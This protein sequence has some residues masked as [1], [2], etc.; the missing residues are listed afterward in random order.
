MAHINLSLR[1]RIFLSMIFLII[2]TFVLTGAVLLYHFQREEEEYHKERLK[3]KEYAVRASIDYFLTPYK[4]GL[5]EKEIPELFTDKICEISNI[6]NLDVAIYSVSGYLLISSHERTVI[7]NITPLRLEPTTL[8]RILNRDTKLTVSYRDSVE[9]L[10]SYSIIYNNKNRPI[11]IINLPYSLQLDGIPEQ[12]VQFIRTLGSIYALL[13]I[14]AVIIAYLLSNYITGSLRTISDSLRDVRLNKRNAKID[15]Q[16]ADEVGQLVREYNHMVVALEESAIKLARN[17]R[18]TAWKEMARQVAH[19]IKNPLTPMRLMVQYLDSTLKTEEPEKLHEHTQAMIDQI[20][21]M[22]SIAEA[23]S[24]F[25]EM[26]EYKREEVDMCDLM[27][28]SAAMY[29]DLPIALNKP[30]HPVIAY[31]DRELMVRVLNNLIKNAAQAQAQDKNPQYEI[32]VKEEAEKI[33]LWVKDNGQGIP[34][35]QRE[36]IFEPSFTTKTQGMGM[37]LAIVRTIINGLN[38]EIWFETE[39]AKGTTF[40][41]HLPKPL[42]S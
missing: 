10:S 40:F 1:A 37:G 17:E 33:L 18:E 39:E 26:P 6:H 42:S 25:S 30:N 12:D 21:A 5:T 20:D 38:G 41:M 7:D 23:F 24:R 36:K 3:R 13:F 15:W 27:S 11:A 28:R 2:I 19:E 8:Y 16:G 32:G 9:Y 4:E 31:V 35:E 22:S 34:Q 14:G 29:P